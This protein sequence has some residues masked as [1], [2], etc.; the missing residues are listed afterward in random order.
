MGHPTAKFWKQLDRVLQQHAIL[1]HPARAKELEAFRQ[2]MITHFGEDPSISLC[3]RWP[4]QSMADGIELGFTDYLSLLAV[5]HAAIYQVSAQGTIECRAA[6]GREPIRIRSD[7]A[8][9][10]RL[11]E[12]GMLVRSQLDIN[13]LSL[14][15]AE[16]LVEEVDALQ[17][18]L[19]VPIAVDEGLWGFLVVGPS[20]HLPYTCQE[21][22]RLGLYGF[23]LLRSHARYALGLPTRS[24]VQREA[25]DEACEAMKILWLGLKPSKPLKLLILEE[26]PKALNLLHRY[27]QEVGFEV[28][29]CTNEVDARRQLYYRS[30]QLCL[31][32]L[33]L[34]QQFP[35]QL[36]TVAKIW[37]PDTVLLG[38]TASSTEAQE[39]EARRLGVIDIFRKPVSLSRLARMIFE[40]ALSL[41]VHSTTE[42]LI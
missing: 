32:D 12:H 11:V 19:V 25:N 15:E 17:A 21:H 42:A 34:H 41:T 5:Q 2:S 27:F 22:M 38:T 23:A 39:A 8:L 20:L 40:H 18:E 1:D 24:H 29:G 4:P 28:Y 7:A 9:L 16:E 6:F 37:Q 31:V 33:S 3:L 35:Q 14:E 13:N 10:P 26:M 36:L 30:P